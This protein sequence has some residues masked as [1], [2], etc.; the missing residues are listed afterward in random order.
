[1][2]LFDLVGWFQPK[3]SNIRIPKIEQEYALNQ[4]DICY[5]FFSDDAISNL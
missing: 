2:F 3:Y 1:M 4:K 5:V